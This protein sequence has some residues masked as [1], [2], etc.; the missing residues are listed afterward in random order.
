MLLADPAAE[1]FATARRCSVG[2]PSKSSSGFSDNKLIELVTA[3]S[4]R[5]VSKVAAGGRSL[6]FSQIREVLRV[7]EDLHAL[8]VETCYKIDLSDL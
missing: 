3:L 1:V 7:A 6:G 4:Q 2:P 5:A 8:Q